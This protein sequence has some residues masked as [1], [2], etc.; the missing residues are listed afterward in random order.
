MAQDSFRLPETSYEELADNQGLRRLRQGNVAQRRRQVIGKDPTQVSRNHAFLVGVGVLEGKR[1]KVLSEIGR[2]L[3]RSLEYEMPDAIMSG[4][5]D[6]AGRNEFSPKHRFGRADTEGHGG[7]S[8]AGSRCLFGRTTKKPAGYG[9]R[10][11][12]GR[13]SSCCGIFGGTRRP[14]C[15]HEGWNDR[16]DD[17]DVVHRVVTRTQEPE[18]RDGAAQLHRDGRHHDRRSSLLHPRSTGRPRGQTSRALGRTSC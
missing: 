1:Q 10:G 16:G 17:R 15:R 18:R 8:V 14:A 2:T 6:V 5:R 7:P 12:G 13:H 11:C 3:A 4:W 9:W